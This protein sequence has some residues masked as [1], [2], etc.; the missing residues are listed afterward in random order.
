M[1]GPGPTPESLYDVDEEQD[2]FDLAVARVTLASG[3]PLL[4]VCRGLQVVNV[5]LG[6]TLIQD[7]DG[8]DSGIGHHRNH[9]HTV[10]AAPGTRTSEIV[11]GSLESSCY[12]HQCLA[13]LGEGLVVTA[14]SE[15]GV[16]EAVELPA[17]P[18]WFLG[19]QWH[20]EDNW[21][22]QPQQLGVL[23]AFVDAARATTSV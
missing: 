13:T 11:G 15:D 10:T 20:P 19:I 18:G 1:G 8:E 22:E 14:R 17:A 5:A 16:I 4:A 21:A 7:M 3:R 23:T 6:G 12:H 9:V 2:A